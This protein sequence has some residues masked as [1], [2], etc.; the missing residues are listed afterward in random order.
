[1]E[2]ILWLLHYELINSG[3]T[4]PRNLESNLEKNVPRRL[5]PAKFFPFSAT[6][7]LKWPR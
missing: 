1:M 6:V 4:L 7:E 5:L 2:N 3:H